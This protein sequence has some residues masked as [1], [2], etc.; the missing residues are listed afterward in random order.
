[1][2]AEMRVFFVDNMEKQFKENQKAF[3]EQSVE[4]LLNVAQV[5]L[6]HVTDEFLKHGCGDKYRIELTHLSA[7]L[8]DLYGK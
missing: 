1:M 6:G 8:Y 5:Q 4:K 2:G 3:G 7:V